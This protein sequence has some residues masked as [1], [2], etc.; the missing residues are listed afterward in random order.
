MHTA[1]NLFFF[2]GGG[3]EWGGVVNKE[4]KHDLLTY[5]PKDYKDLVTQMEI[6]SGGG[7][8]GGS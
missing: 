5:H 6:P 8:G 3:G 2:W 1:G 7:G 4:I